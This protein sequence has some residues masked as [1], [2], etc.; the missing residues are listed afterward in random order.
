MIVYVCMCLMADAN[1]L[2]KDK[3]DIVKPLEINDDE[4]LKVHTQEYLSC[5]KVSVRIYHS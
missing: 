1:M 5:M 3:T 2:K 4:L